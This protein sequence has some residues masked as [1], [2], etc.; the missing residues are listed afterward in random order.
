MEYIVTFKNTNLAIKAEQ[1]LLEQKLQISVL[2]L[3]S[4][5][6]VGCGICLRVDQAEIKPALKILADRQIT[7]I[8]LFSRVL[9]NSRFS[10]EELKDRSI[11]TEQI[12][13][14]FFAA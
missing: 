9:E 4:Q 8:G 13:G 1:C 2:P 6:N 5:I 10:Y 7:E 12:S 3:P 11:F 14:G